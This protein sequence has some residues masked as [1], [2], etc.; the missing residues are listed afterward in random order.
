MKKL[1]HL[2]LSP[3]KKQFLFEDAIGIVQNC[4]GLKLSVNEATVAFAYSKFP[5]TDEMED[6]SQ[7]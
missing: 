3:S 6:I 7:L 4:Q 1:F 5:V 2:Y